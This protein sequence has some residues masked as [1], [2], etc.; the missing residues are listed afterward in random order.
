LPTY[1]KM[2]CFSLLTYLLLKKLPYAIWMQPWNGLQLLAPTESVS[3]ETP[4]LCV[5]MHVYFLKYI[6]KLLSSQVSINYTYAT[7]LL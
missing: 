1:W 6:Y 4:F 3:Q 7:D 5:H 2:K